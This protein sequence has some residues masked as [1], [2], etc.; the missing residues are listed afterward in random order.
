[1][2]PTSLLY[3]HT[4]L[5][6]KYKKYLGNTTIIALIFL[7]IWTLLLRQAI[8]P[9]KNSLKAH[10]IPSDYEKLATVLENDKTFSRT[11]WIPDLQR[12]R[13]LS[14]THPT[15]AENELFSAVMI[16][17]NTTLQKALDQQLLQNMSIKYIIVPYDS[18][19]EIFLNNREYD[20]TQYQKI[21][22][23]VQTI[24]WLQQ[25]NDFKQ[26]GVFAVQNAKQHFYIE[27]QTNTAQVFYKEITETEYIVTV[28]NV[29]QGDRLIFSESFS[30]QWYISIANK[31]IRSQKYSIFNSFILPKQG[32]YTF[33]I[34]FAPQ[35]FVSIGFVASGITIVS[36]LILLYLIVNIEHSK[37]TR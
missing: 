4:W 25:R 12:Y 11:L 8:L 27:K 15:I 5:Q 29:K 7:C 31:K 35:R 13:Y 2:I 3:I 32:D 33:T 14:V 21:I 6:K 17:K 22:K 30:P 20:A 23:T 16:K 28:K 10:P 37:R 24:P 34:S 19:K 26:L 1:M 9:I 36:L 18:E